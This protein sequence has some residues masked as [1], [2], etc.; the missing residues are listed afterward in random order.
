MHLKKELSDKIDQLF[1]LSGEEFNPDTHLPTA[2]FIVQNLGLEK[3]P[4][5]G[6]KELFTIKSRWC[7]IE[8][9]KERVGN[10][11]VEYLGRLRG[12]YHSGLHP[13]LE[14]YLWKDNLL[15]GFIEPS[16]RL[17][18]MYEGKEVKE[19]SKWIKIKEG[20]EIGHVRL[21]MYHYEAVWKYK[22]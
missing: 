17:R 12:F 4:L 2:E 20:I 5:I 1:R 11:L 7:E 16:K 6:L 15:G 3:S 13:G 8:A 18:I 21:A 22:R 14:I 9:R 10:Y 19:V